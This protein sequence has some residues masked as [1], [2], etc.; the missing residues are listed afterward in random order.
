[1]RLPAALSDST[2]ARWIERE[3]K[4]IGYCIL[5]REPRRKLLK[6]LDC[7]LQE[8]ESQL[9][10]ALHAIVRFGAAEGCDGVLTNVSSGLYK[11]ALRASGFIPG[12]ALRC[13]L[14][15]GTHSFPLQSLD[16]RFWLI[17]PIDRDHFEY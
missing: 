2:F 11:S 3:G 12:R 1:M 15:E 13:N 6:I 5:F 7:I 10:P 4:R 8:P 17:M 9:A 14:L 16:E